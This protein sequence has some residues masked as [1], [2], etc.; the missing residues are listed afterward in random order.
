[1]DDSKLQDKYI[2][3]HVS[4]K[5]ADVL[6][7][8]MFRNGYPLFSLVEFNIWG[9]CNRTCEFCP[10]SNPEIYTNRKEGISLDDYRKVLRDLDAIDYIGVILWSMFSEPVLHK[11]VNKLARLTKQIL[12]GVSLQMTSN[13]DI[14]RRR[15]DKLIALFDSG[16]DRVNLSLYDGPQQFVEFTEIRKRCGLS[17][18][19]IK[20]R[21]RYQE[22][23][24]YGISISNRAGLVDSNSYRDE[25]EVPITELPLHQSCYYPF[26]QVAIDYNGDVLLCPHDWAK[27]YIA[28]NAFNQDIWE[29]WKGPKFETARKLL[30]QSKR[31]FN[32][33]KKC[34]VAGNLIGRTNFDAFT[35]KPKQ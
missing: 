4:L 32:P 28:G 20:L 35:T 21:R 33:C 8:L 6:G 26:Y 16:V 34:D 5:E 13:G 19:Q 31:S 15:E 18:D 11:Q 27:E 2:D 23:G 24:N 22:G 25:K 30:A 1:V 14:F 7:S 12:P 17:T 9:A 29:I 3:P 10:V